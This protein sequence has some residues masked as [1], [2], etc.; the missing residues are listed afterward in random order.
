MLDGSQ[1][2]AQTPLAV[3]QGGGGC[4]LPV[5]AGALRG[6]RAHEGASFL[7]RHQRPVHCDLPGWAGRVAPPCTIKQCPHRVERGWMDG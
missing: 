1:A 6:G 7:Q 4:H 5:T 3:G 2:S